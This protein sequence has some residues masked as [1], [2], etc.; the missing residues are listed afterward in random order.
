MSSN[1][2]HI[3]SINNYEE[4]FVLYMDNELAA[5]QKK[6]VE[7]FLL[8]HPHLQEELDLLLD[9]RLPQEEVIFSGK[10]EL[11]APSMKL[12]NV[13]EALLLY[14]D[15]ELPAA[16]TKKVEERLA[17]DKN[18]RL[19]YQL[20]QKTKPDAA[21]VILYP[22]KEE[23]Y[24]RADRRVLFPVWMRAAAALVLLLTGGYFFVLNQ[25]A[26][27]VAP[28]NVVIIENPLETKKQAVPENP[29]QKNSFP[30]EQSLI[31]KTSENKTSIKL[32]LQKPV[33]AVKENKAEPMQAVAPQ[34]ESVAIQQQEA[35]RISL[36]KLTMQSEPAVNNS[37]AN[38]P[39]TSAH[40]VTLN[41]T[42]DPEETAVTDG[43]NK[44]NHRTPAKGFLRKVSR[45]LERR[46]GIGTVNA[47][48]EL[49]VGAVVLKLN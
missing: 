26:D 25:N 45:F 42:D 2:N 41:L 12:N 24:R 4:W 19:Q 40:P 18:F 35:I 9:T 3:I 46:T 38:L 31:A 20:L 43:D 33:P 7:D 47:D 6:M 16:E 27:I 49:L 37:V 44:P 14:L 17:S 21:E 29:A 5:A 15:N 23:L 32:A 34:T 13:E 8:L 36:E 39:V 1:N 11:L 10:E 30:P 48:N 28:D 22:N